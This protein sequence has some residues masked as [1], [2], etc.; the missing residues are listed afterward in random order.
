M[1]GVVLIHCNITVYVTTE[2]FGRSLVAFLSSWFSG[3]CVPSFYFVSGLLFFRNLNGNIKKKITGRIHSL[4]VPYLIW[5][6]LGL[7]CL[8]LKRTMFAPLFP[9]YSAVDITLRSIIDGFWAN[10]LLGVDN[11]YPYDF[12]MWFVRN[13]I[14]VI[15]IATIV[16]KLLSDKLW[17]LIPILLLQIPD[18]GIQDYG[19]LKAFSF[20]YVGGVSGRW[21]DIYQSHSKFLSQRETLLVA[22][23]SISLYIM[24]NAFF[25]SL[26]LVL[27]ISTIVCIFGIILLIQRVTPLNSKIEQAENYKALFFI[28]CAHGLWVT[29]ANRVVLDIINPNNSFLIIVAYLTLFLMFWYVDLLLFIVSN[30]FFPKVTKILTGGRC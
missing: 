11:I 22:V 19:L 7:L 2:C 14:V 17:I 18:F 24:A 28:Y 13:L 1:I 5:N 30:R 21:L 23:V 8:L 27:F 20:F 25:K 6:V 12:V 15:P 29:I 4:G 10:T 26:Q 3:I 16:Y 9:Q